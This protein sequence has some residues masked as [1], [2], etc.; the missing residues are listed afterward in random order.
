VPVLPEPRYARAGG[1]EI[2]YTLVGEGPRTV[3]RVSGL[4]LDLDSTRDEG[5][6]GWLARIPEFARFVLFDRRGQGLSSRTFGFGTPED[7]MDDIRVVMDATGVDDAVLFADADS[8]SLALLFAA[9]YPDRVTGLV[10]TSVASP[11]TR[12]APDYPIGHPDSLLDDYVEWVGKV[13]G[14][15]RV[16]ANFVGEVPTDETLQ[17]WARRERAICNPAMA[18]EH[19]RLANATDIRDVLPTVRAPT[20][21]IHGTDELMPVAW[22]RYLAEHL[23][24]AKLIEPGGRGLFGPPETSGPL[25]DAVEEFVTGERPRGISDVDRVLA[26]VLFVDIATSTE[27]LVEVGDRRWAETITDFRSRLRQELDR[28]RGR[29]VNHRGD[30]VLAVFDGSTRAVRCAQAIATVAEGLGLQ[31]RAGAHT[32]EVQLHGD[33]IAG[34][35]VNTCA[36]VCDLA[37]PGEILVTAMLRDL[38]AGSGL[39]FAERGSHQ[40]KGL[41]GTWDLFAVSAGSGLPAR[42]AG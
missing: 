24:D 40:L 2:A 26:T 28:Y 15:G 31:V 10:L 9:T 35:A 36:R 17:L 23:V 18:A 25:I 30:D 4:G 42:A 21:I 7:R 27:R 41:P 34:I 5:V 6:T 32:G 20:L 3:V 1:I 19:F 11:R 33:D 16:F 39:T 29:E 38:V 37:A 13:W 8:A 14:T 22:A 12:W